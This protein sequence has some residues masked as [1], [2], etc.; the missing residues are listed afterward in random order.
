MELP[1]Y[2]EIGGMIQKSFTLDA[3]ALILK[4]KEDALRHQAEI[5]ELKDKVKALEETADISD[6]VVWERPFYW[7][8]KGGHE[9]D[10]PYCQ[11][12]WDVDKKPIRLQHHGGGRS[13][14]L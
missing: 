14:Y 13:F 11:R 1:N 5:I 3:Q 9:R 8:T 10:G 7:L 4:W 6:R 2:K 12:C